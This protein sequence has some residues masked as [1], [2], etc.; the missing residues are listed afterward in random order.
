MRLEIKLLFEKILNDSKICNREME[1][2][3]TTVR[4]VLCQLSF[5]VHRARSSLQRSDNLHDT[6][7]CKTIFFEC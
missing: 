7:D 5:H 1:K 3:E 4:E 2:A 6:P